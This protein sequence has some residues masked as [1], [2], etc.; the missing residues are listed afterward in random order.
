MGGEATRGVGARADLPEGSGR[1]VFVRHCGR[2]HA[3]PDP[4]AHTAAE[5]PAVVARM[6][7]HMR[8]RG[9]PPPQEAEREAL[10][11]YL[12]RHAAEG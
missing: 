1:E 12:R 5:W 4:A 9:L 11:D 6:E 2:C 8:R 7:R 3:P 10:L